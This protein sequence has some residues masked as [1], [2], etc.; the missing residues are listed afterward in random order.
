MTGAG[1]DQPV[2]R[3]GYGLYDQGSIPSRSNDGNL[4][5][6]HHIQASSGA[7]PASYPIA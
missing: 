4:S 3:L 5:L 2:Q 6:C 1:V 7:H